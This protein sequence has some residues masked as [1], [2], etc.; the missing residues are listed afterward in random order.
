MS[1]VRKPTRI[2]PGDQMNI[3][4]ASIG[5]ITEGQNYHNGTEKF[6][7]TIWKLGRTVCVYSTSYG[8]GFAA[9]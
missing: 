4:I 5:S 8:G 9:L 7:V 3:V 1:P 2:Y 6:G